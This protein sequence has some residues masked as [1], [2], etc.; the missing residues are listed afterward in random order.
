MSEFNEPWWLD[1]DWGKVRDD[2]H[3]IVLDSVLPGAESTNRN[4][5]RRRII[6][7]VNACAGIPTEQL[8][9]ARRLLLVSGFHMTAAE[10]QEYLER[11]S[12]ELRDFAAKRTGVSIE[13]DPRSVPPLKPFANGTTAGAA[14]Q[15]L[16][17]AGLDAW[18]QVADP[19]AEIRQI[20]GDPAPS[21]WRTDPPDKP[22]YYW[23]RFSADGEHGPS[24]LVE[25]AENESDGILYFH[26]CAKARRQFCGM[27]V[28]FMTQC[29]WVGPIQ[30]PTLPE[31]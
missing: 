29:E 24:D 25:V 3:K 16:R 5:F 11:K 21:K 1:V 9:D 18:D 17:D 12:A 10:R 13:N 6:A 20:R 23:V 2:L 8:E 27:G 14:I 4:R 19:E 15:K 22:G 26:H 31:T 7:C 30:P 28:Q